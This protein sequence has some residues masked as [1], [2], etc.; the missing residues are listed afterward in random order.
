M[1]RHGEG[2]EKQA[3]ERAFTAGTRPRAPSARISRLTGAVWIGSCNEMPATLPA[4]QAGSPRGAAKR[5]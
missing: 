3:A 1:R 2:R 4:Q 5:R